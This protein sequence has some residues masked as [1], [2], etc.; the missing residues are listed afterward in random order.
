MP[1]S[2]AVN[3]AVAPS[4]DLPPPRAISGA[5]KLDILSA[6]CGVVD[7]TDDIRGLVHPN[8]ELNIDTERLTSILTGHSTPQRVANAD[9]FLSFVFRYDEGPIRLFTHEPSTQGKVYHVT[10]E[11][12]SKYPVLQPTSWAVASWSIVAIVAEGRHLSGPEQVSAIASRIEKNYDNGKGTRHANIQSSVNPGVV[13]S[14]PS[15][16]VDCN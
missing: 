11:E 9:L 14:D 4:N 8:G 3:F 5:P 7:C 2:L 6:A 13:S 10:L 16:K 15:R 1:S 12:S